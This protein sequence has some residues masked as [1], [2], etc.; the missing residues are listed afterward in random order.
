M[1]VLE[2]GT[3][4]HTDRQRRGKAQRNREE[5]RRED[6]DVLTIPGV[7]HVGDE[8]VNEGDLRFGHAAGVPVKHR[9]HHGQPLSLLLIRLQVKHTHRSQSAEMNHTETLLSCISVRPLTC[10][11]YSSEIRPAHSMQSSSGLQGFATS[12]HLINILLISS[13]FS[14]EFLMLA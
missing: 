7:E 4:E 1:E 8:V 10:A 13:R 9:H 12:A 11:K 2:N 14:G 6:D 3:I 5:E